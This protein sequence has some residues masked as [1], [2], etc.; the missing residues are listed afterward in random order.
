VARQNAPE[1]MFVQGTLDQVDLDQTFDLV[2]MNCVLEHL[3]GPLE[4]LQLV[5]RLLVPGGRLFIK[6]PNIS[7]WEAFF[8]GRY[9]SGLD[10]PRHLVHFP[11]PVLHAILKELGFSVEVKPSM[12]ASSLSESII[13][14]FQAQIGKR[15]IG[16]R[17]SRMLYLMGVFPSALLCLLGNRPVVEFMAQKTSSS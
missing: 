7:S 12:F 17:I 13:I 1:A 9:W 2:T 14:A 4:T 6:V 16:G 8:F 3:P 10:V 11:E 15:L 5:K